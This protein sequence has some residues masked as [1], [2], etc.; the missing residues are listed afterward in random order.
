MIEFSRW[1]FFFIILIQFYFTFF[2]QII[3]E[4]T[5][6][7]FHSNLLQFT[8]TILGEVNAEWNF[9]REYI[10]CSIVNWKF[11]VICVFIHFNVCLQQWT[12]FNIIYFNQFLNRCTHNYRMIDKKKRK[13]FFRW[14]FLLLLFSFILIFQFLFFSLSKW[15]RMKLNVGVCECV[16]MW[17]C[18]SVSVKV[19]SDVANYNDARKHRSKFNAFLGIFLK[20]T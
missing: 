11:F 17:M 10:L 12:L 4:F 6:F 7:V 15:L 13:Q 18:V 1:F 16:C 8:G 14:H 2:A 20:C 3:S 9:C 19:L 5:Q